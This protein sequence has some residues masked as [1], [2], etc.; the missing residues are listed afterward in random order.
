MLHAMSPSTVASHACG[1][2]QLAGTSE[3]QRAKPQ[4]GAHPFIPRRVSDINLDLRTTTQCWRL[5][6]AHITHHASRT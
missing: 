2:A 1:G 5:P 3:M 4:G 6:A